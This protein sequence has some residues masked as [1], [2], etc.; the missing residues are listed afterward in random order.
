[1]RPPGKSPFPAPSSLAAPRSAA[2]AAG[3]LPG[4]PPG[5]RRPRAERS[6]E[7]G[8]GE[9][10]RPP[11]PCACRW[12]RGR[13]GRDPGQRL[14]RARPLGRKGRGSSWE[15]EGARGRREGRWEGRLRVRPRL[16]GLLSLAPSPRTRQ[17]LFNRTPPPGCMGGQGDPG[18]S[19][20]GSAGRSSAT[21]SAPGATKAGG[22]S[23]GV[24]RHRRPPGPGLPGEG[25]QGRA[26]RRRG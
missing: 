9:T 15:K 14:P 19:S 22:L 4:R 23:W 26:P 1:M 25:G 16:G 5:H 3:R 7:D 10:E 18:L 13:G 21:W 17:G 12:A 8:E 11:Q 2:P 20:G 24:G 6:S